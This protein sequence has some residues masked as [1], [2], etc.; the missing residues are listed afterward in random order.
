MVKA[1]INS[2]IQHELEQVLSSGI[3]DMIMYKDGLSGV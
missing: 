1:D 3:Y 2:Q